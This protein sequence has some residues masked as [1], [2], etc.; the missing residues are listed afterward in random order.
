MKEK[1]RSSFTLIELLVVIAIIAI[2]AA[3]LLPALNS[4]R[5]RAKAIN[6]TSQL[7][8]L[9]L[10]SAMYV[11]D[12][13]GWFGT[14]NSSG[15]KEQHWMWALGKKG[16]IKL[17]GVD[18]NGSPNQLRC[19][20]FS[21]MMCPSMMLNEAVTDRIQGYAGIYGNN[22]DTVKKDDFQIPMQGDTFK[23]GYDKDKTTVVKESVPMSNRIWF[24]DGYAAGGYPAAILLQW[25]DDNTCSK[26]V[27]VHNGNSN[28][29]TWGGDVQSVSPDVYGDWYTPMKSSTGARYRLIRVANYIANMGD[30][31]WTNV[32]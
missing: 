7:K 20:K 9:G 29:L 19:K 27:P 16:Y 25:S 22:L 32:K 11:N 28:I 24:A 13:K 8:Q 6:C 5:E 21:G 12:N 2:L 1:S 17:P 4:A 14:A 23:T 10:A 3:M 18:F 31:A 30:T 26:L 15:G